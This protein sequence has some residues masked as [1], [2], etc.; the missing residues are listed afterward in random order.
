[1]WKTV[2]TYKKK[3]NKIKIHICSFMPE[4]ES[5]YGEA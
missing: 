4:P 2:I 5:W 3:N 1:M